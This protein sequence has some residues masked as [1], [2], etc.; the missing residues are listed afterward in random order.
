[1]PPNLKRLLQRSPVFRVRLRPETVPP[2]LRLFD[3]DM[4]GGRLS[5]RRVFAT[6]PEGFGIPDGA[7]TDTD[8]GYWCALHGG[9]SS[10][11]LMPMVRSIATPNCL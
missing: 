8:G 1:M 2:C 11:G 5:N 4:E 9:E 3:Y 10:A 7:A 6:I